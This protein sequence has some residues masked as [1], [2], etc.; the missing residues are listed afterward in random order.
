MKIPLGHSFLSAALS[1]FFVLCICLPVADLVLGLD[2]SAPLS[3]NRQMAA[4]PSLTSST[5]AVLQHPTGIGAWLGLLQD[6]TA[7]PANFTRYFNDH[8]GFRRLLVR[9]HS[10]FVLLGWP[11]KSDVIVGRHGWLFLGEARARESYQASTSF[12]PEELASWRSELERRRDW[13]AAQGSDYLLVI[14]PEKST[15]Y[16]EFMP[17]HVPRIGQQTRLDQLVSYLA[18][19]SDLQVIDLREALVEAGAQHPT[20]YR[21]DTHWTD[22]GAF[23]VY[24]QIMMR[25]SERHPDLQLK[26]ASNYTFHAQETVGGDLAGMLGLKDILKD[27]AIVAEPADLVHAQQADT[28]IAPLPNVP[29]WNQPEAREVPDLDAPTAI[30][31]RDSFGKALIPFLSEHFRRS[32]YLHRYGLS[33]T[34][35]LQERPRIVIQEMAERELQEASPSNWNNE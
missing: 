35:I 29:E 3:E 4:R 2:P 22:W 21:T 28:G 23:V 31:F 19:N 10:R 26:S 8:F 24:Q 15:I 17:T 30:V 1:L 18:E 14:A 11:S 20:Y 16:P 34:A 7:Y 27:Q 9:T 12:S 5:L 13:L 33:E 25:L 6:A 32:L